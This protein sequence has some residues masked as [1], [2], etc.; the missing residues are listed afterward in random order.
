M[1]EYEEISRRWA[2]SKLS[3]LL[4]EKVSE[5]SVTVDFVLDEGYNCCGGTDPNCY[6]S[7]ATSPQMTAVI[8][9]LPRGRSSGA[10][11]SI[12]LNCIDFTETLREILSL[13]S[14]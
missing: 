3:P 4:R 14:E 11:L 12:T 7:L 2:L 9:Y 6:C 13:R 10:K 8:S 5:E 1:N